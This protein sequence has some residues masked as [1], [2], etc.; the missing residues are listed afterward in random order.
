MQHKDQPVGALEAACARW[1]RCY[2]LHGSAHGH[3]RH[4]LHPLVGMRLVLLVEKLCTTHGTTVG[5]RLQ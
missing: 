1:Q 3:K 4:V 2:A 5:V